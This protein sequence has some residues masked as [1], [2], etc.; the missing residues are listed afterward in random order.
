MP[1]LFSKFNFSGDHR[2]YFTGIF[3]CFLAGFGWVSLLGI[4]L[5]LLELG[6]RFSLV[7]WHTVSGFQV[8]F[9]C[10]LVL[11]FRLSVIL[12]FS[13]SSANSHFFFCRFASLLGIRLP[14]LDGVFVFIHVQLTH[15]SFF[16]V[17][18][19]IRLPILSG[20]FGIRLPFGVG[21]YT[22]TFFFLELIHQ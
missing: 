22:V 3:A 12:L 20:V 8:G 7:S 11:G 18:L 1:D 5:I 10:F 21:K 15:A 16:Q 2:R 6:F 9:A 4:A 14:V 13:L 17:V 19:G